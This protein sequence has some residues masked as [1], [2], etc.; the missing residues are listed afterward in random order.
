MASTLEERTVHW[1]NW[2]FDA[3]GTR[4]KIPLGPSWWEDRAMALSMSDPA[5]KVQLFRFVDVLPTLDS[6]GKIR[7]HLVEYLDEAKGWRWLAWLARFMPTWGPAGGIVTA[8]TRWSARRMARRFIVGADRR[9]TLEAVKRLRAEGFAATLDVLGEA[10][11]TE[12]EAE[13]SLEEYLALVSETTKAMATLP[14]N[15][16]LDSD[17]SSRLPRANVSVKVSALTAIFDP[18]DPDGTARLVLPRLREILRLARDRGAFVHFDMEQHASKD[19]ILGLFRSLAAEAEFRDGPGMG[20]A[21]QAYLRETPR[22]LR[23]LLEWARETRRPVTVRLVKGAYWDFETIHARQ[24][25]WPV[26]VWGQKAESDRQYEDLA[27]FLIDNRQWLRPAFGSH[28]VRS[29]AR[30]LALSELAEL[31]PE[32]VEFQSLHGMG[33]PVQRALRSLGRRVRVYAPYGDLLPG[34]A[35][36]VRRLL[37]NT[38]N[39]SFLRQSQAEHRERPWLLADPREKIAMMPETPVQETSANHGGEPPPLKAAALTDF[40][41]AEAREGFSQA[42]GTVRARLGIQLPAFV[43]GRRHSTASCLESKNPSKRFETIGAVPLCTAH[44]AAQAVEGCARFQHRYGEFSALTRAGWL[45][46]A[47]NLMS[48]RRMELAAWMVL[49]VGKSWREADGD[50]AEAIDFCHY[51]AGMAEWLAAPHDRA[52]PGETNITMRQG[53]GVAAVIAPWNFP[54]A[55]LCGMT[56]AALAAG[57]ATVMKPAEQSPVIGALLHGI[58]LEAGVP[59]EALALVQGPGETVG[60]AL[61]SHPL[62]SVIAFTGSLK[63]GSII[64]EKASRLAPGQTHFKRVLAEM[65]GKNAVIIDEDA[66]LDEAI[67]SVLAG[68]FGYQ[69]QKCSACSRLLVPASQHDA[70]AARLADAARTLS[71]GPAE[72]PACALGPV[73][74]DE[75]RERIEKAIAEGR[76][77]GTDILGMSAGDLTGQGS[78]VAPAIFTGLGADDF[79]VRE[80]IFGPVLVVQ[81]YAGFDEALRLANDTPFALTAGLHSRSPARIGRFAREA[82]A[83]NLYVNRKVTGAVVDRQ[84]FGGF[85]FSG[86]GAKAGGPDYLPQFMIARTV[87][88]N[89]MRRGF[90]PETIGP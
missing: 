35:Y 11:L 21:I 58:F 59:P 41:R 39:D 70:I 85:G 9:E 72:D 10:T 80:E 60:D 27:G 75:A 65:G 51:Y 36:L 48:A 57:C 74:D 67:R 14:E 55:I 63:V 23:E 24:M 69:G 1:G 33:E 78:F 8:T 77:R 50:V 38:A 66:D 5:L 90:S 17:G 47:A 71:M 86:I 20:I 88:E 31:P 16:L 42:L 34:M 15:H 22:D 4:W 29:L 37:E 56:S 2:L 40:T 30:V 84:P 18:T 83:G 68:A 62:T 73:I 6:A 28:N 46:R 53:R 49:E 76:Q 54:L 12:R 81:P 87:T 19:L 44:D 13:Q 32:V 25:D 52:V 3:M 26:P 43:A 64:N 89:T 61:V 82:R 45:R 79:L 7:R